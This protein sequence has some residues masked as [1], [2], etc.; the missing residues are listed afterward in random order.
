MC[1]FLVVENVPVMAGL[2][3]GS[4]IASTLDS[5]HIEAVKIKYKRLHQFNNTGMEFDDFKESLE[6][7]LELKECYEEDL[8]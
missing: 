4:E 7:L 5:L 8:L 2:H 1:G 6:K 3:N